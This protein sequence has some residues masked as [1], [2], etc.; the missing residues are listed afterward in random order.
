MEEEDGGDVG[1]VGGH[2]ENGDEKAEFVGG[3]VGEGRADP[4]VK[5][6][7]S[8]PCWSRPSGWRPTSPWSLSCRRR[9]SGGETNVAVVDR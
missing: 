7:W 9:Q 6:L 5:L 8:L 4:A 2:G 1:L 3:G